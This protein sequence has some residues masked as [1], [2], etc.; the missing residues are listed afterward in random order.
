VSGSYAED[1]GGY[2]GPDDDGVGAAMWRLS[3]RLD[4]ARAAYVESV[5]DAGVSEVV[6]ALCAGLAGGDGLRVPVS[7]VASAGPVQGSRGVRVRWDAQG[8]PKRG[9]PGETLFAN[10]KRHRGLKVR[11]GPSATP[12]AAGT[13]PDMTVP[14]H[15]AG[16]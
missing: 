7:P 13:P 12:P 14:G 10:G 5:R 6:K 16:T 11:G 9:R 15:T 8:L 1:V 3:H 4:D 2:G